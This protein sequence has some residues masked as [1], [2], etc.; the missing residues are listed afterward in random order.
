MVKRRWMAVLAM[1]LAMMLVLVVGCGT[2]KS[3]ST[4]NAKVTLRMAY[5]TGYLAQS[6]PA[7]ANY[8][9]LWESAPNV[10]VETT[11][12]PSAGEM[13]QLLAANK[14]DVAVG[15]P[16]GYLPA[17]AK[18]E[19]FL[20]IGGNGYGTTVFGGPGRNALLVHKDS[21]YQSV[22]DLKGKKIGVRKGT[23]SEMT[24]KL[25]LQ[26]K[27]G[28]EEG[29]DYQT[30]DIQHEDLATALVTKSIDAV[31]HSEPTTTLLVSKFKVGK[32]L[33]NGELYGEPVYIWI[34]SDFAKSHPKAVTDFLLG[35]A[36]AQ[37]W[38]TTHPAE[39]TSIVLGAIK[40][41]EMDPETAL[42]SWYGKTVY[43]PGL[44]MEKQYVPW[45]NV[46]LRDRINT[47]K[48]AKMSEEDLNKVIKGP[49]DTR[50]LEALQATKWWKQN[51]KWWQGYWEKKSIDKVKQ[52]L[53][54]IK[55]PV[56]VKVP[57]FTE[58]F[59]DV[60]YPKYQ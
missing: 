19:K 31:F 39:A 44:D 55:G 28:M 53:A 50:F 3:G 38:I 57:K 49:V 9:R 8:L 25:I 23:G 41:Y 11:I 34:R 35:Y 6:T 30:L 42:E 56:E 17:V 26:E 10:A 51:D 13:A 29:R 16:S 60:K 52:D 46:L 45:S 5:G 22:T 20:V 24:L 7:V 32:V 36:Y 2:K 27:Y 43:E 4:E 18:G 33:M 59:P 12:A 58:V 21:P 47:G 40:G 1:L 48:M 54:K 15:S 37:Y 14:A